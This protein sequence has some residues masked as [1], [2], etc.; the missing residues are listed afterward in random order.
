MLVLTRRI[1][2]S[3]VIRDDIEVTVVSVQGNRVRLGIRAPAD[4]KV[5]REEVRERV[6]EGSVQ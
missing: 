4:V 3:V 1:G 5:A 6:E 2:E